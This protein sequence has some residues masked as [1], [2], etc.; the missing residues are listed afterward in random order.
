LTTKLEHRFV[1]SIP[2]DIDEGILYI[3]LRFNVIIHL[4]CCG[5]RN[6]V[7][8]PLSPVRWRMTFDGKT[9]SLSP[10][11]GNWNF[12]CKSHYWIQNSQVNWSD[13]WSK[14][15]IAES[16][17][18]ARGRRSRYYENVN[19]FEPDRPV[20][21]DKK[22]VKNQRFINWIRDLFNKQT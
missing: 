12:R 14:R 8:T 13:R 2:E 16:K 4:C 21:G 3:S 15:E 7:V 17:V 22:S 9:I 1:E 10:S 19:T 6:K 11:I 5:C 18:E 20:Q